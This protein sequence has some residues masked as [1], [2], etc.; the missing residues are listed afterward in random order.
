M[1]FSQKG[2]QSSLHGH[3]LEVIDLVALTAEAGRRLLTLLVDHR[4][5]AKYV[6]WCGAPADPLLCLLAEQPCE[7]ADHIGW[8]L[9]L[10]DVRAVLMA[11]GYPAGQ[12][13][14]LH[15]QV[16]D[17][18]LEHNHRRFLLRVADSQ[19]AVAEGGRGDLRIDVRGLAAVYTGRLTPAELKATGYVDGP[20]DALRVAEA[21]FAGPAPWMPDLF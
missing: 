15:L 1:V 4:S 9:R 20:D 2:N 18:V 5:T 16:T 3:E 13:A 21:L 10:V 12:T 7:I 6:S 11:R 8:M 17:D 19:A 14:E